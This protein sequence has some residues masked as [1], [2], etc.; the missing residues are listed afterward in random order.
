MGCSAA[1]YKMIQDYANSKGLSMREAVNDMITKFVN[2]EARTMDA[3]KLSTIKGEMTNPANKPKEYTRYVP[4]GED[5]PIGDRPKPQPDPTPPITMPTQRAKFAP[6][7]V[8]ELKERYNNKLEDEAIEA[9]RC[10][11][12]NQYYDPRDI[13][14]HEDGHK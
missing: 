7:S 13:L 1:V 3:D 14:E 11:T 10:R 5:I 8:E 4:E 6:L 2:A 9:C 12:C